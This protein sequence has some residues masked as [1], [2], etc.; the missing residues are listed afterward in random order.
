MRYCYE[1]SM[2]ISFAAFDVAE[3]MRLISYIFVKK[4]VEIVNYNSE[5]HELTLII[6]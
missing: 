2:H 5:S 3:Q 1:E 6:I 4:L